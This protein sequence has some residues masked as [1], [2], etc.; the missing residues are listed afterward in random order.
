MITQDHNLATFCYKITKEQ[1]LVIPTNLE[2]KS[3]F[4]QFRAFSSFPKTSFFSRYFNQNVRIDIACLEVLQGNQAYADS[5]WIQTDFGVYLVCKNG[6]L[7]VSQITLS[8]GKSINF[9][10]YKFV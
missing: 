1:S 7:K 5:E 3:L 4:A 9:K 6:C 8:S 2:V 10:G